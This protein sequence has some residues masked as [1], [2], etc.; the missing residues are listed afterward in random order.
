[1][2]TLLESKLNSLPEEITSKYPP[3]VHCALNEINPEINMIGA[4]VSLSSNNI[5]GSSNNHEAVNKE[6][7]AVSQNTQTIQ[8][9]SNSG[10]IS[11][12]NKESKENQE[13]YSEENKTESIPEPIEETPEQKLKSFIEQNNSE[14]LERLLKMLKFGIQEQAVLQKARLTGFDMELVK[15]NKFLSVYLFSFFIF[16]NFRL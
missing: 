8:V 7:A 13:K 2:V 11:T 15:V 5:G 1:M 12:E 16:L 14:D 10:D 3:L 4:N 6:N 9:E